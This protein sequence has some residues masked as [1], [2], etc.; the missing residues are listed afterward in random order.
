M[1]D[2]YVKGSAHQP[3]STITGH[4]QGMIAVDSQFVAPNLTWFR[5]DDY[6]KVLADKLLADKRLAD[7]QEEFDAYVA[8]TKPAK[9]AVKVPA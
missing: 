2:R 5:G 7:L 6:A 3:I 1:P 8:A 9:R 4:F